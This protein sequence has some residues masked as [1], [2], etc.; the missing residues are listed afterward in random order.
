MRNLFLF[1][2]LALLACQSPQERCISNATKDL[3]VLNRLIQE[4][5]A[6]IAR[7][8]AIEEKVVDDVRLVFCA[9]ADGKVTTCFEDTVKTEKRPVSIDLEAEKQ[10]LLSMREKRSQLQVQSQAAITQCR[11]QYSE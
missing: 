2:P 11:A 5:E 4:T 10:K 3:T 7:G 8:Y 1:V 9:G 6:N